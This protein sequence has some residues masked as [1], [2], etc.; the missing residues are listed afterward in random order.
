MAIVVSHWAGIDL[1]EEPWIKRVVLVSLAIGAVLPLATIKDM[2]KLS[3]SSFVSLMSVIFITFV[4]VSRAVG[5]AGDAKL[6]ETD[7]DKQLLFIDTNFFPAIGII[8]FA[9]VCHH[10]CFIVYNTLENN[11]E[12][13]WVKTVHLSLGIAATVMLSL[14]MAA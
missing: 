4:V 6:P 8:S 9:F 13:R 10:A 14:A 12:A 3:K 2:S 1:H 5:G 11:T 7:A